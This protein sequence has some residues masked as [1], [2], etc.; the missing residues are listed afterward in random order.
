[1]DLAFCI[2][3]QWMMQSENRNGKA[4]HVIDQSNAYLHPMEEMQ[5]KISEFF[6]S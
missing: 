2:G 5:D 4:G 3:A 1:M 6:S